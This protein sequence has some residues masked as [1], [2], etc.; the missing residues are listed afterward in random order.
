MLCAGLRASAA[1]GSNPARS[2]LSNYSSPEKQ[3]HHRHPRFPYLPKAAHAP[4]T[5]SR[6]PPLRTVFSPHFSAAVV[7]LP[8]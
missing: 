1:N 6:Y 3:R 2:S 8:E 7:R 4:L 5:M